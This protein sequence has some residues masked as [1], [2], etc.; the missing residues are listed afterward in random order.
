MGLFGKLFGG[1]GEKDPKPL[2]PATCEASMNFDLENVRP[3]LQRLHERRGIGLDVD[4]LARFAE[5]TEPE[6]EREMRRD[7]TYEGRTVPV[8]F[9]VFMDDID[10]PDLYF[11]APD[12]ALIDAID[13]EY[14]VFC[15]ELGI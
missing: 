7:F 15:D 4:A 13:A 2:A 8:R 5:E 6:D 3:F 10:A 9:S 12:K 1:G 11:Y 14:V